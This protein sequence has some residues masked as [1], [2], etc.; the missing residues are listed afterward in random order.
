MSSNR[1]RPLDH[2]DPQWFRS[3]YQPDAKELLKS[4]DPLGKHPLTSSRPENQPGAGQSAPQNCRTA[5][6]HPKSANDSQARRQRF[7]IAV[8]EGSTNQMHHDEKRIRPQINV[9]RMQQ[10]YC[11]SFP[12]GHCMR[13]HPKIIR[14][15]HATDLARATNFVLSLHR[16]NHHRSDA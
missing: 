13:I 7:Q 2:E 6:A 12:L 16:S 10:K 8:R 1:L 3:T 9:A 11:L 4:H 5:F 14:L 15:N